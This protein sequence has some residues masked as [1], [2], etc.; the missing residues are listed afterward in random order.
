MPHER[1]TTRN[2]AGLLHGV[3]NLVTRVSDR[4]LKNYL[5]DS[6]TGHLRVRATWGI[7]KGNGGIGKIEYLHLPIATEFC[8]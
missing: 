5:R 7:R 8:S 4:W 1:L 2:P 3:A 6:P